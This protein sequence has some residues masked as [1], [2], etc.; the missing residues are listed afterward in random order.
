MAGSIF[1]SK[2]LIADIVILPWSRLRSSLETFG[3]YQCILSELSAC[4]CVY[5]ITC[6]IMREL[7]LKGLDLRPIVGRNLCVCVVFCGLIIG[8]D[9]VHYDLYC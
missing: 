8:A 7:C 4:L 6:D 2:S 9:H 1:Q 5:D 3:N